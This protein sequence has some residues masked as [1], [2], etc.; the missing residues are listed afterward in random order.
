MDH[1]QVCRDV[2]ELGAKIRFA[3]ACN[4]SGETRF[5]GQRIKKSNLQAM[6]RRG[7][8]A[9]VSK[10]KYAMEERLNA[11]P[12]DSLEDHTLE[13]IGDESTQ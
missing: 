2:L 9:K 1:N 12:L 3:V 13:L 4:E 11:L 8:P 7:M 5:G 6:A 10:G